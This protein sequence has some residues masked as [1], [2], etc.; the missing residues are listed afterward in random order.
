MISP[1]F[2][3]VCLVLIV[4]TAASAN[5]VVEQP[6]GK[7]D[8]VVALGEPAPP[9]TGRAGIMAAIERAALRE[10]L[11][12]EIAEA[13]THTESS[14][15]PNVIGGAGEIG[16]MQ[17]LPSTARMMGFSG[18]LADL[19]VPETNIQ[20]GVKYLAR[21]WR[22]GG[23]DICTTVM[24]YR[25]GHGETRFSHLSVEYC[26]KVRA[27][28]K[29]RGYAVAGVVPAATF[30][31]PS[32]GLGGGR[33]RGKGGGCRGICLAGSSGGANVDALNSRMSQIVFRVKTVELQRQ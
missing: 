33:S 23:Q 10:G 28:L 3:S 20:Y 7:K 17:V 8:T 13:V 24:K 19:A 22:L 16:L 29:A 9:A 27:R 6:S 32:T 12:A 15:N 26:L 18:S 14:F 2:L 1:S 25:A 4:A 21:A 11:P 30:G 5:P 31:N